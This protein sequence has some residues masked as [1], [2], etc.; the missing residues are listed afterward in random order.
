MTNGEL[1]QA[2]QALTKYLA[3]IKKL[4]EASE[5]R[6]PHKEVDTKLYALNEIVSLCGDIAS[7][8]IRFDLMANKGVTNRVE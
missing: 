2:H 4:Y 8:L 7:Y 5:I 3:D 1:N 6:I